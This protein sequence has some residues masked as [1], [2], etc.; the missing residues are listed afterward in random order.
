[1]R[2]WSVITIMKKTFLIS[3]DAEGDNFWEWLPGNPITTQ[4]AAFVSRF[5]ELCDRYSFKP[6]YLTNY[7]MACD[8]QF[9]ELIKSAADKNRCE[10]GM[11]LHAWNT[12][13]IYDLEIRSDIRP[14]ECAYL[15]EY[16][17]EVMEGKI[18]FMTEFL[19]ETFGSRP[20][21]HRAGRWA[22]DRRYF[23]LLERYGYLADC[24]VTPGMDMRRA[25]GFT[26]GSAGSNYE[27]SPMMPGMIDGT[28]LLE[29]PMTVRP[30]HRLKKTNSRNPMRLLRNCYRAVKGHGTIWVR[31]NGNNL[32]EMK[33]LAQK[34]AKEKS[35]Y[36]MFM[37]HTSE[38]MPNG[39]P[40]FRTEEDIE[41][42]YADLEAFF[43]YVNKFYVGDTIGNYA[44]KM[45]ERNQ[46]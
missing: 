25:K 19:E 43:S 8:A 9:V 30:N 17:T 20:L 40:I 10:V 23:Q 16:P 38:M 13:P 15:I 1:M 41:K 36:L 46:K 2:K 33:Y 11:H 14:G 45:I 27:Y 18:K 29:I 42:L 12:P 24:S 6:T 22:T 39:S 35:D 31:P 5:Q 26:A 7:E 44:R 4:N 32:D 37:L 28:E 21:V 3:I 34:V